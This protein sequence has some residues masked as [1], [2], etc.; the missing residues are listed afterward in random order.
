V[1]D[2]RQLISI[3][4]LALGIALLVAT[5]A[6]LDMRTVATAARHLGVALPLVIGVSGGWHVLRTD[7][8]SV[9]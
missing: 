1:K 9:V 7:R 8:K 4:A 5:V 6:W 3:G 2:R